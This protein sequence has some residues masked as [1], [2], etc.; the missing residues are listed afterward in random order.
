MIPIKNLKAK[1]N[2]SIPKKNTAGVKLSPGI[3]N[4]V[5]S[6]QIKDGKNVKI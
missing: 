2:E 3:L 4:P 5:K 6:C 1:L